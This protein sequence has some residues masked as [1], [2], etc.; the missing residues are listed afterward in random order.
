MNVGLAEG[1]DDDLFRRLSRTFFGKSQN[2]QEEQLEEHDIERWT[3]RNEKGEVDNLSERT[4][5]NEWRLDQH[6][7]DIQ[8]KDH[9]LVQ[10]VVRD[11]R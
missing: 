11:E 7:K 10:K 6:V 8:T 4:K 2:Q 9:S 3:S 5:V 1:A